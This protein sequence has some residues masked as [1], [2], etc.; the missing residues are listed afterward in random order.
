MSGAGPVPSYSALR[1]RISL[2]ARR[3]A[4]PTVRVDKLGRE[5]IALG[6]RHDRQRRDGD[7]SIRRVQRCGGGAKR[8]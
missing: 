3:P 1:T 7:A 8:S 6:D 4:A 5:A 2:R